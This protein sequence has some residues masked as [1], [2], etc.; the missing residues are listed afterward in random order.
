LISGLLMVPAGF[1]PWY[2]GFGG[3][4]FTLVSLV[5]GLMFSW[6]AYKHFKERTEQSAKR[7]MYVSFIYLPVTQLALLFNFIPF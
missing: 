2:Y 6:Y 1:L 3:I 7:V 5:G 4:I